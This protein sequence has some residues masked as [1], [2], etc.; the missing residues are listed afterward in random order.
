MT[1]RMIALGVALLRVADREGGTC[2][3][4]GFLAYPTVAALIGK[5]FWGSGPQSSVELATPVLEKAYVAVGPGD[6][7]GTPGY[8]RLSQA[9]GDDDL[10]TGVTRMGEFLSTATD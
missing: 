8:V 4:S 2:R 7:F 1:G 9:F 10:V 6:D 5:D 3:T